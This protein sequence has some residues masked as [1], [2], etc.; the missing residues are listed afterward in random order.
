M[1]RRPLGSRGGGAGR[2]RAGR[3]E[4]RVLLQGPVHAAR[5]RPQAHEHRHTAFTS[6]SLPSR[7]SVFLMLQQGVSSLCLL[8]ILFFQSKTTSS[9]RSSY[10]PCI[11]TQKRAGTPGDRAPLGFVPR[12]PLGGPPDRKPGQRTC[13]LLGPVPD[14]CRGPAPFKRGMLRLCLTQLMK[15]SRESLPIPTR[16]PTP[17]VAR[18][19]GL[20]PAAASAARERPGRRRP[21]RGQHRLQLRPR[22]PAVAR[23]RAVLRGPRGVARGAAAVPA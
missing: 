5:L 4:D 19:R 16:R 17:R 9:R 14:G 7:N 15:T 1:C 21:L 11:Q 12:D 10:P 3:R 6:S 8:E 13:C 2:P 23:R 22:L 18:S 20:Q